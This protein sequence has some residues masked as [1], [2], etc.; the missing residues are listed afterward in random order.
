MNRVLRSTARFSSERRTRALKRWPPPP[1]PLPGLRSISTVI[2][3][4]RRTTPYL[5]ASHSLY[6]AYRRAP[7]TRHVPFDGRGPCNARRRPPRAAERERRDGLD[8]SGA[9]ARHRETSPQDRSAAFP[10][11]PLALRGDGFLGHGIGN[12]DVDVCSLSQHGVGLPDSREQETQASATSGK[13]R[14]LH[15]AMTCRI[16][17]PSRFRGLRKLPG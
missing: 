14:L 12:A 17:K 11:R 7:R 10:I 16:W 3:G 9:G 4:G 8:K 2:S 6:E 15:E 5:L 1:P 13:A